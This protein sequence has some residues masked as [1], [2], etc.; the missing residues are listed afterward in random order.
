MCFATCSKSTGAPLLIKSDNSPA[1]RAQASKEFLSDW[2]A[3]SLFSLPYCASYNGVCERAN[4]TMKLM[5]A[6]MAE[7]AGRGHWWH[8]EDLEEARPMANQVRRL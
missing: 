2:G 1:F 6:H 7:R 8:S 5:T 3:F 4:K